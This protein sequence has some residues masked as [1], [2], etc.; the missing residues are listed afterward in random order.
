MDEWVFTFLLDT[1]D[2][3]HAF[4]TAVRNI[5]LRQNVIQQHSIR[6]EAGNATITVTFVPGYDP[7]TDE[8]FRY[9]FTHHVLARTTSEALRLDGIVRDI[10]ARYPD[11]PTDD[12]TRREQPRLSA[13]EQIQLEEDRRILGIIDTIANDTKP[14][15]WVR[16]G[17]WVKR[18]VNP[19]VP[20][21]HLDQA[22]YRQ[23]A[24]TEDR[25][26][27]NLSDIAQVHQVTK[28][29]AV[30]THME[31]RRFGDQLQL[32]EVNREEVPLVL[33]TAGSRFEDRWLPAEPGEEP[34]T[35]TLPPNTWELLS[36]DD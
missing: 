2:A 1:I 11:V 31:W 14:P 4:L 20:G 22:L 24:E 10:R 33:M 25:K 36:D 23:V 7:L 21:E 19:Q 6:R 5:R 27:F 13:S 29:H 12:F 17:V 32:V 35:P 34:P 3:F 28:S 18:N 16:E 26:V 9:L 8:F 15:D 30:L